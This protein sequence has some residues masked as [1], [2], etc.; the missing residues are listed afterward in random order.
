MTGEKVADS[1]VRMMLA[2]QVAYL[3]GAKGMSVG[4][5]INRI[6]SNYDG[7]PNLSEQQQSQLDTA[8]YIQEQIEKYDMQDCNRWI[9]KEVANDNAQ[10]GFYGCLIDTRDG[11]AV[12]GFRGSESF[13]DAQVLHDWVE[14]DVG[15]L[16]NTATGQQKLAEEF[17]RYVN[18]QYGNYYNQYNFTGHSLGGNLAEHATITAPDGM[19]IHRCVNLDGP[20][21]SNE[22]IIAHGSDIAQNGKYIDHYQYSVT[23]TLLL[24][25][26]GTHYQTIKA[27]NDEESDGVAEYFVR[28]HTRN[29]EFD[30]D[31]GVQQG[32][33][34]LFAMVLGP[35]SKD[36]EV[37]PPAL[38][39][40]VAPQLAALWALVETGYDTLLA[41]KARAEQ[42]VETIEKTL[43]SLK[44]TISNWF[45]SM[46]GVALTGEFE[47]NVSYVNALG[48]GM[49]EV[50]RK[51]RTISNDLTGIANTL[52]YNSL[53]GTCF[54]SKLRTMSNTVSRDMTKASLLGNA[55][56]SC[57]QQTVN[58]DGQVSQC[59]KA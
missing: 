15:L 11:E 7:W 51:L 29:I 53:A 6:I 32:T 45:R 18:D 8:L 40:V 14:A 56:R 42:L 25:L 55:I 20:G 59:F 36:I 31:G 46:F 44:Q 2:T 52:R 47:L 9:I 38:L 30:G 1:D 50:S 34:D 17:T 57:V 28:H 12:L 37:G 19:P 24:P 23:G 48:D 13:D 33:Q 35:I 10:S 49:D 27:H 21:Y 41:M 22:Y 3:D 43:Q 54:K 4:D 58:S 26:P 39:W 16:N 5:L